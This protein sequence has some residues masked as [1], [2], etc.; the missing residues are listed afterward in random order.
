MG[1]GVHRKGAGGLG[2]L[3]RSGG[4]YGV[5][6]AAGSPPFPVLPG[7]QREVVKTLVKVLVRLYQGVLSPL[8]A[9][10]CSYVPTCSHYC[11]EAVGRHGALR[12]G[13]LTVKRLARC[14]P[15]GGQGY[16]PVP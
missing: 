6:F 8:L 1:P 16:D 10:S 11:Y 12:G 14:H 15:W 3:S 9:T 5:S 2:G 13:W 4:G 7:A